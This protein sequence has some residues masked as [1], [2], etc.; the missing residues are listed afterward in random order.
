[1][2]GSNDH[3][4]L[5]EPQ[6]RFTVTTKRDR[7]TIDQ[8][9]AK[10]QLELLGYK[11]GDNV[12]MRFFV[13]DGDP[14]HGTPAAARK[15]DKLNWEQVERYQNEGYGVYFVVNGGGHSDKNIKVGRSLFCEW[16]DRSIED[17]LF[18]WQSLN[19]LEPTMQVSTRKSVHNYWRADLTKEQ[20]LELQEDLLVYTQSDQKLKNPSRVLRLAGCWHIKPNCDPI[21]CD[22]MHQSEQVYTY[23]ELRAAIPRRQEPKHPSI[24]YQSSISDDVPLYQF[25]TKD[26]RKLIDQGAS[27]GSRNSSGAKLARNLIGTAQRLNHL[28]IRYSNDPHHLLHDYCHRCTPSLST[29]EAEAIWRSALKDNPT[30]SLTDDVLENCAKAWLRNQEKLSGRGKSGNR[31]GTVDGGDR[32][33]NGNASSQNLPLREAIEK[34]TKI[35]ETQIDSQID[36]IEANILLEEL[37]REAGVNEYNWEHKYLKPLR[38]KLERSLGLPSATPIAPSERKR[39]ELKAIAQERDPYKFTDK[40]IEFCRRTGWSRRDVEQQI[41]L[42]KTSTVT[43]KAKRLKGK[44]FL[45]LETESISWV[46]PGI[47]PSRGVFVIGGDAGVGKTTAA[48][49]AVG[50][51][52]LGEEF[53]GEK[54]VKSGK[55]LIVSGDELPCFTQDKLIDRGIPLDDENWDIILNWDVSQWEV[56]EEA[57]NDLRPALVVIDSFSSIHRDPSFDENSSQAKSTIYDLEALTNAYGCGCILIHHLSKSKENKGVAKLRGSSAI[58]AAASVVCLMEPM[59]DGTRKLSFPKVRG[60]QTEPFLVALNGST[61]RYEVVKGGDDGGTKSL[62]ER[63][64]AFLQKD[65]YKRFEQDQIS[66]ALGIPNS[67][68]DSVYQALG[69]L[70]KRGLITKRPSMLGG[71]RKVYGINTPQKYSDNKLCATPLSHVTDNLTDNPQDTPPPS[72]VKL[73]VQNVESVDI[74]G[75]ELTDNLTDNLTDTKLT[76]QIDVQ[77]VSGSTPLTVDVSAKLTDKESQGCVCPRSEV[78]VETATSYDLNNGEAVGHLVHIRDMW[79]QLSDETWRVVAWCEKNGFYTL[80]NGE[81]VYPYTLVLTT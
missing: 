24:N 29:T 40:L 44:D 14:R 60:A 49:D 79:K 61:G 33:V 46:F 41:R 34:A 1:V 66:E 51:L 76:P 13:P 32:T 36:S 30:P 7:L 67:Q 10:I 78:I 71:K 21:R 81:H 53:L 28:G 73:S 20:W 18:A 52:L 38:E 69:R 62:G 57:I 27:Q 54:P 48:Y 68:R 11:P 2:T 16:D 37:R 3:L 39:L 64:L 72:F 58:A 6:S 8:K 22:I 25:L 56:L 59:S 50:S 70:F 75:L 12:Y 4:E 42:F 26:D 77:S 45:A 74:C 55:V 5:K 80:E 31:R 43:P 65:P 47:I 17:Q 63:I 23:E 19:L 9:Q 15:T 35:L